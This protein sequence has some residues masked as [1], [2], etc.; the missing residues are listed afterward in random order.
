M[1]VGTVK[2]VK[3]SAD[4]VL[5]IFRDNFRHSENYIPEQ[6]SVDELGFETTIAEWQ[7]ICDLVSWKPLGRALNEE[8]KVCEGDA[9]WRSVLQPAKKRTLR[10]VCELLAKSAMIPSI[11]PA[12]ILGRECM[13]A[14]AFMTIRSLFKEAGADISDVTPSTEIADYTV[15]YGHIFV[16]SISPLSP[17]A[18]P[19]VTVSEPRYDS[20]LR[21]ILIGLA[22]AG[23]GGFITGL[24][25]MMWMASEIE[26]CLGIL[27][28][29]LISFGALIVAASQISTLW[30]TQLAPSS[31]VF[32]D[33]KTFRDLS[34]VLADSLEKRG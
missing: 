32:G 12:R 28:F 20:S 6:D 25:E 34:Q 13:A 19:H 11:Q 2:R 5:A 8:W 1:E 3:A 18:I 27:A 30:P 16:G 24:V 17:N 29:L 23:L 9:A 31:V 7:D 10:G 33:I 15:E 21:C 22:I 26:M 4:D 14:G